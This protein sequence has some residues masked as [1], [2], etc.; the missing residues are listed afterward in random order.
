MAWS[1]SIFFDKDGESQPTGITQLLFKRA[2]RSYRAMDRSCLEFG[3]NL[4]VA[5]SPGEPE[6]PNRRQVPPKGDHAMNQITDTGPLSL[7]AFEEGLGPIEDRLRAN[8]RSTI[9]SVFEEELDSFPGR[10][11]DSRHGG[12]VKGYRHGTRG[13]QITGTFGTGTV[14]VP[15]ARI[16]DG[17]WTEAA[18]IRDRRWGAWSGGRAR[19]PPGQRLGHAASSAMIYRPGSSWRGRSGLGHAASSAMIYRPGSSWRGR[20]GL[21]HAASSAMMAIATRIRAKVSGLGHA[22]SSAMMPVQLDRR[23]CES[24]LGHAASSAMIPVRPRHAHPRVRAWPRRF[25][26]YDR[27]GIRDLKHP[28]RAWPRRFFCYDIL[29]D[30]TDVLGVRAWPRRF[31]CYD[32][33]CVGPPRSQV[34][35]WPRRFFCYD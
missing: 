27:H 8:I 1:F 22:A 12:G 3:G 10:L 29:H 28:V 19:G 33:F 30:D 14:S 26:C 21:G 34:R 5:S 25:F 35:A 31:F 6:P 13:R 24:G 7:L 4:K 23:L 15:R 32:D 9:E 11:R 17:A 2:L 20:S 16:E 18:R